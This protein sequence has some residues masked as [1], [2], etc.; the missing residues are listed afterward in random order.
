MKSNLKSIYRIPKGRKEKIYFSFIW[1]IRLFLIGAIVLEAY[2]LRWS[3]FFVTALALTLTLVPIFFERRYSIKIPPEFH[4][5]IVIF[6]YS[7]IYLGEVHNFYY[8]FFWWDSLLHTFAGFAMAI[9]GFATIFVL[10]KSEKIKA[11]PLLVTF[12]AFCFSTMLSI[13]WEIFE[14]I[15]D[16]TL[17]LNMQKVHIGSGVTDTM[18]DLILNMAGALV[19]SIIG[20][21]Y[22][23]YG[24]SRIY[25]QVLDP[26][27]KKNSKL[28]KH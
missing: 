23:K 7:A 17:G 14:F 16:T 20:F 13:L 25:N 24:K 5:F 26:F 12:F 21:F 4:L 22:L 15:I 3:L 6:I 18:V 9:V 8:K 27:L 11:N 2:Y 28:F 10:Y 19:S 1:V